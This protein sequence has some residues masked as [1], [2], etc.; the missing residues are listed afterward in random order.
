MKIAI[1]GAH[2]QGKTTL[3]EALQ[4]L[5]MFKDYIVRTSFTRKLQSEGIPINTDGTK[6]TQLYVM[7]EHFNRLHL[8]DNL[9][10]DRSALDGIAYTKAVLLSDSCQYDCS[11]D[12]VDALESL[13]KDMIFKYDVI[14]YVKP[15]LPLIEDGIRATDQKFFDAVVGYFNELIVTAKHKGVKIVEISGS[16]EQRI[17]KITEYL[18]G[19]NI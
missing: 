1:S 9:L 19:K 18:S 11:V 13:Y 7:A 8:G 10:L 5:E 3:I 4:K 2:S 12:Y 6:V 16:V 14:F 15:E 17:E